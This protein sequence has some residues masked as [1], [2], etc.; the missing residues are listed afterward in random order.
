MERTKAI[1]RGNSL[2]NDTMLGAQ[3]PNGQFEKKSQL[4][5]Y[6]KEGGEVLTGGDAARLNSGLEGAI[7]LSLPF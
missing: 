5:G 2:A 1:K 6:R 7:I 4:Y 3:A